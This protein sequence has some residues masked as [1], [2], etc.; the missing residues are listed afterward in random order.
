MASL[1]DFDGEL[2]VNGAWV[3]TDAFAYNSFSGYRDP[4]QLLFGVKKSRGITWRLNVQLKTAD[5]T[6][7]PKRYRIAV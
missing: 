6:K 2:L 5:D 7:G 1:A 4:A 3:A